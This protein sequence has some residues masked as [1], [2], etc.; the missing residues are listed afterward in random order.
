MPPDRCLKILAKVPGLGLDLIENR[1][2]LKGLSRG[3]R[4]WF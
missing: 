2:M 1:E 4:A 3:I